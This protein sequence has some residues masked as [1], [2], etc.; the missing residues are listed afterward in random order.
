MH[1]PNYNFDLT[2]F[3]EDN[4]L[5]NNSNVV[6]NTIS[7]TPMADYSGDN[8][9]SLLS[10]K[11]VSRKTDNQTAEYLP[12][13]KR[14]KVQE[15][16]ESQYRQMTVV[17]S[18]LDQYLISQILQNTRCEY[19]EL[20]RQIGPYAEH[21]FTFCPSS[22]L[23][24]RL[25]NQFFSDQVSD[26]DK[27]FFY[28][29][30]ILQLF[31]HITLQAVSLQEANEKA[32]QREKDLQRQDEQSRE[33]RLSNEIEHQ[34]LRETVPT[35]HKKVHTLQQ[36]VQ[37]LK[38]ELSLQKDNIQLWKQLL[39]KLQ[40]DLHL[41]ENIV[42]TLSKRQLEQKNGPQIYEIPDPTKISA[43]LQR[44][45]QLEQNPN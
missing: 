16:K 39:P 41:E 29:Q 1:F 35:L 25:D 37:T 26:Q 27:I 11:R 31:E 28:R 38:A 17:E 15:Q 13:N 34:S 42:S 21:F 33:A 14:Q 44:Q 22:R 30:Y 32:A 18:P 7:S 8:P 36:Q 4:N 2:P 45:K 3:W 10:A 9:N 6:D 24:P 43:M 23:P 40:R 19:L 5:A 12:D 20:L